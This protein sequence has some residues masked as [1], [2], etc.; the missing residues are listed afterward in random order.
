MCAWT[1]VSQDNILTAAPVLNKHN[2]KVPTPHYKPLVS[3][4]YC[5]Q[6]QRTAG[7]WSVSIWAKGC[8]ATASYVKVWGHGRLIPCPQALRPQRLSLD[9]CFSLLFPFGTMTAVHSHSLHVRVQWGHTQ[10]ERHSDSWCAHPM[11]SDSG[12]LNGT[13]EGTVE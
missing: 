5:A 10:T 8:F 11:N 1:A 9:L 13:F 3:S 7:W 2:S 12:G 6:L 4:T